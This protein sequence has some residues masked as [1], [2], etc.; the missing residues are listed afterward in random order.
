MTRYT[1]KS[2]RASL[3]LLARVG[4]TVRQYDKKPTRNNTY[5]RD[6]TSD[7][8]RD[9]RNSHRVSQSASQSVT[10]TLTDS[11][12]ESAKGGREQR[13]ARHFT[14]HTPYTMYTVEYYGETGT[15]SGVE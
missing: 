11:T 15:G 12:S 6:E 3:G 8:R 13:E 1:C 7:K 9:D 14:E 10:P 2:K 4:K 5:K